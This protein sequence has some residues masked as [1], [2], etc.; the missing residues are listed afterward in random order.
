PLAQGVL[1]GKYHPGQAVPEG[2]RATDQKGGGG[3]FIQRFLTDEILTAVQSLEPLAAERNLTMAQM[4]LAWVLHNDA[5]AA[6]LIGAS[7][8]EQIAEN[9]KASGVELDEEAMNA[10]D[11]A[12]AP[13]AVT[14]PAETDHVSPRHRLV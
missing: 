12:L 8:P 1:T 14:D 3:R 5:I 11:A 9:V 10:I 2:S 4:G 6:A 13:V 7:R